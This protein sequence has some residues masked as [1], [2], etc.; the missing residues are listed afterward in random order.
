MTTLEGGFLENYGE[1]IKN[2]LRLMFQLAIITNITRPK[3][4]GP[5]EDGEFERTRS[6]VL[7]ICCRPILI[8]SYGEWGRTSFLTAHASSQVLCL[9]NGCKLTLRYHHSHSHWPSMTKLYQ[10]L[11]P[12]QLLVPLKS[13][14]YSFSG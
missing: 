13:Q 11:V 9:L 8:Y 3:S 6:V 14:P 12:L 10:M 4:K 7:A 5:K 2:L 1:S